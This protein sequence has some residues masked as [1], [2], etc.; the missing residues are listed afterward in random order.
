[1]LQEAGAGAVVADDVVAAVVV[2]LASTVV[3]AANVDAVVDSVSVVEVEFGGAAVVE[4]DVVVDASEL[5][6][7]S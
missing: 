2:V 6:V 5:L 1:M 3:E 4:A 7:V